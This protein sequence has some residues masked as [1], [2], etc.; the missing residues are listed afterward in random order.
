MNLKKYLTLGVSLGLILIPILNCYKDSEILATFDGGTVTRKEMNFVIEAS[1]RGNTEPQPISADIQAK[2][3]ES[4]ALEKILLKDAIASKKVAEADV[5]KIESLVNQFLKLNVYMREYVKNGLKEKPLEFV[6]LQLALVRGEDEATN[7]KKAEE[8]A[9]KLNS[10]SDKEIAEE[11]SKVTDDIT[12]RPIA[13]KLEPFCTNCAETPLED[14]L[15]E[16]KK[17]NKGTFISYAKAGEGRIAYV[18]RSTGTEKVHPERLRKYFTSIF[19]EFKKEATEYGKTHED[20]ETKA[21]VA[22]FTEGESADKANQFASHTMKE[23]EQ[24]LYQKELK[25]ITEESGIT[26][27]NLPRFTGPN[28]IDPK[29]FTPDYSLYSNR[30]GKNYTWKD[31][32]LEFEAIPNVLKQEYKDE[33]SKTWD[34]LNLFQSTILQGKIAETSDR[35][36]DVGSEIGYLMQ[37]DKMKVSLALK[38]LQDE[39]KAIPVTVTEAQMRDAYEAGKMYAYAD[40]DPKN[41]QN[42]IPKPYGAVRERIKSEMEGAQ[43]N[44][45]IEQKVS[46][47]KTTYNLVIAA[48]R[49]KEVTL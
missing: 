29:I 38:S 13:G 35:V 5:Q 12:R 6:N 14:I 3:L 22:Y 21:S 47:L 36:Q 18:V 1:K 9:N 11:I 25:K 15:A 49:L 24:G 4:I 30:E 20:P 43:R 17:A 16:V 27:A 8:L 42:R 48:D 34:M 19:D 46:G 32:T 2:I 28:D 26:V 45:F 7:L 31:L 23:Y 44:S 37:M 40:P 10:L 33:K 41:P 39:I